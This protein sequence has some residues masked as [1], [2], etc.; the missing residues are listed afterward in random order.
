MPDLNALQK[1]LGA[2]RAKRDALANETRALAL[3]AEALRMRRADLDRR[4]GNPEGR[5]DAAGLEREIASLEAETGRRRAELAEVSERLSGAVLDFSRTPVSDAIGGL[6]DHVPFLMFPVRLETKFAHGQGGLSLRVRIFPDA[7]NISTHDPLLSAGERAAGIA[8]WAERARVADLGGEEKRT[9]ELG[10]WTLLATRYGGP[11]ARY[12]A[13]TTRSDPQPAGPSPAPGEEPD[14]P[15]RLSHSVAPP[16]TRLLPDYFVVVGIGHNGQ[17]V[18]RAIGK[19]IPDALLLGPDPDAATAELSRSANGRLAADPK[20]DWLINFDRAIDVGMAVNLAVPAEQARDG[21]KQIIALGAKLTMDHEAGASA[22]EALLAEHRFTDGIDLLANG[23]PTNNTDGA[24]AAFTSNLSA[25]EALVDQEVHGL[26]PVEVLDHAAK[27]DAQ[28]LAEAL[29]IRFETVSDWPGAARQHDIADA[30][31]MNKALW[32]AT[33]GRFLS[34]MVA[35]EMTPLLKNEIERYFLTYVTGR[36]LLPNIR[37]GRQPYGV[38]A[39]SDLSTWLEEEGRQAGAMGDIAAGLRWFRRH[40]EAPRPDTSVSIAQIGGGGDE[41]L[42]NSMRVIGQLASS[43][44][45]NSRKAVTDREAWNTLNFTGVIPL[46]AFN[47]WDRLEKARSEQFARLQL[48]A[49]NL[50]LAKLVYFNTTDALDVPV[51]DQDPDIP[52]SEIER[53]SKFDGARNY[54]DWLLTA[55]SEDLQAEVFKN[56]DGDRISAP[57]ALLYR[58]L[59]NAWTSQLTANSHSL[60]TRLRA[61]L[62]AMAPASSTLNIGA[63]KNVPVDHAPLFDAAKLGLTRNARALGDLLLDASRSGSAN[64]PEPLPEALALQSQRAALERLANLSTAA[65]ERL[66]AEHVDLASYRLDG[67]QTGLVSRR[68]DFMRR[69][70][71]RARGVY[72]GAYGYVENLVPKPAPTPVAQSDLPALLRDSGAVSELPDNGGFVQT[73]SLTHA[74]TAAVLRNAYLTHA[75]PSTRDLMSVNLTSRRV[76]SAMSFIEG[77]RAGQDLSALLGYQFERGLHEGHPGLELDQFIYVLRAKFP[78]ISRRLTPVDESA[79]A[80]VIEARNV[81]DGKDFLDQVRAKKV[82][83]YDIADLPAPNSTEARAIIAEIERLEESLDAVADLTLAESAHQA[84]QSNI[85]R[86]R[87]VLGAMGDGEMPPVPDVAQTPR[88]G[89]V[90]TQRVALHLSSGGGPA[91]TTPRA[92]ANPGLNAWLGAQLPAPGGIGFEVRAA[93]APPRTETLDQMGLEAIDLVLMS[94]DRLGDGANDLE[95]HLADRVRAAYDVGDDIVMLFSGPTPSAGERKLVLDAGAAPGATPLAQLL[96]QLRALRRLVGGGRGLNAQ[97]YRL[98]ADFEKTNPRNPKGFK[99]DAGGDLASLPQRVR[100]SRDALQT[101]TASL[102][103]HLDTLAAGY[104]ALRADPTTFDAAAWSGKLAILRE[105]MRAL[106]MFGAPDALP[107]S[108]A[109]ASVSAV[110]G[111]IE[112]ARAALATIEKRLAA[113][114]AALAPLPVEPPREDP[115]EENRRLAGRLDTRLANLVAAARLS[116]GDGFPLQPVFILDADAQAEVDARLAAPI[117]SDAL[118]LEAWLQSLGRVRPR[119]ADIA[120]A[121][122]AAF[123]INGTEPRLVPVQLPLR[124][125]DPW[126][127]QAWTTPPQEG[128]I[129]SVMTLDPPASLGSDLEGLLLD[130]WTETVPTTHETTGVAF[131]FDRPS[132]VAPQA[133]LLAAPPNPDG[134]W[135]WNELLHVVLDTFARARLRAIEPDHIAASDLF[136]VLPA[137]VS[138]FYKG[139]LFASTHLVRDVA[140]L[141]AST[142]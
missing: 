11:R 29:G 133:L 87:G 92:A 32:P 27:S 132:A 33:F 116:L 45:F 64:L 52:L 106:A 80:E 118:A 66:F 79:P 34:E 125:G 54:I 60:F 113:A 10:A 131:H 121:S 12:I 50:P 36:T 117:E 137:T 84:V 13:R 22:L 9:A 100:A 30:L 96:P 109:G 94:A 31:A 35:G 108:S 18:T 91:P 98:A 48:P 55:T 2:L 127:G 105:R 38:L 83:P 73:P 69:R 37:I 104:D 88:S 77:V 97:D 57:K 142:E 103:N 4:P 76:R 23:A 78:L 119:I 39:T 41:A 1:E 124:A 122:A 15:V 74:V 24:P 17:E 49:T 43:V 14:E 53:I 72:L 82:Y 28:R 44:A 86:A 47:W 58:M 141:K 128:E 70:E 75:E 3:R 120:L 20:L 90:F 139:S 89:R 62:A 114:E 59:H 93:G 7:V 138:S 123:W 126:I 135:R 56:S 134:R 129:L 110:F 115:R 8:Y 101:A 140:A 99:L 51:V 63:Q 111:L 130:E 81:I 40:F 102:E 68:L 42:A 21:F 25:D 19:P 26:A 46:I 136:P 112:Q 65:L 107:R 71:G 6:D 61:D 16:R 5:S 95:R 85:D 67:W